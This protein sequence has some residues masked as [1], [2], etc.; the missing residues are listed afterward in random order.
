MFELGIDLNQFRNDIN[1]SAVAVCGF[2]RVGG[3]SVAST[4]VLLY[5]HYLHKSLADPQYLQRFMP[6]P[7]NHFR[8]V[9]VIQGWYCAGKVEDDTYELFQ[10]AAKMMC[11]HLE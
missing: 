5:C 2:L 7:D 9:K 11:L 3:K 1:P 8:C 4:A 10:V 6:D